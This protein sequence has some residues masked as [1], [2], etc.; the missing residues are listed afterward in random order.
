[1]SLIIRATPLT[2]SFIYISFFQTFT[3]INL[4]LLQVFWNALTLL[5]GTGLLLNSSIEE[6]NWDLLAVTGDCLGEFRG[7]WRTW[8]GVLEDGR[9]YGG[10]GPSLPEPLE[11]P[12]STLVKGEWG[13]RKCDLD[14]SIEDCIRQ[15]GRPMVGQGRG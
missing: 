3:V 12:M 7:D 4:G 15:W 10:G 13:D 5:S 14:Q 6:D 2:K 11:G 1:M 8:G 9:W